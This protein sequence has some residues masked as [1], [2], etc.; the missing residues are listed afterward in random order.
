MKKTR[1]LIIRM[2]K[3][4]KKLWDL[5]TES[6]NI[7]SN[8]DSFNAL[9]IHELMLADSVRVEAY[10]SAISKYVKLGDTVID[11]GTGTGILAFF[12]AKKGAKKVYAIDHAAIISTA[13]KVALHNNIKNIEFRQTHSKKF[14]LDT[15][16]DIIIHE[17]MGSFL[18]NERMVRNVSDLRDRLLVKDGIIIPNRFEFYIEPVKI[19]DGYQ[20]PFLRDQKIKDIDFSCLDIQT[21]QKF[22]NNFYSRH[23]S[24]FDFFL[25][26]PE[27]LYRFDLQTINPADLPSELSYSRKIIRGGRLDGFVVYFR[28]FIN[29]DFFLST[30]PMEN[31]DSNISWL[32][33]ILRV[34]PHIYEKGEP[35]FFELKIE[36]LLSVKESWRWNYR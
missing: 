25:C 20:V 10:H 6:T 16:V 24:T 21:S 7:V 28:C 22:G 5:I 23:S 3:R 18:F 36:E 26:Q 14:T 9:L 17:Q 29:E 1:S 2:L 19:K 4:N 31:I 8:I 15:P 13:K 35:V 33:N 27:P 11:L 34:R 32:H 30:S 12:A